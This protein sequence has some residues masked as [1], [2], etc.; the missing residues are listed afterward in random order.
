MLER[1]IEDSARSLGLPNG[2]LEQLS[3]LLTALILDR[4]HG[5]LAGFSSSFQ[6]LGL[7][8]I[9]ASWSSGQPSQPISF[10]EVK[11]VFGVP[12]IAAM[13]GKLGLG[14]VL[15]TRALC[16]LLPDLIKVLTLGDQSPLAIPA[17]LRSSSS[18][19]AEWLNEMDS[20]RWVA[21]RT[22]SPLQD[23]VRSQSKTDLCRG[24]PNKTPCLER[25]G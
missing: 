7:Q 22:C 21:W 3:G 6:R 18:G 19:V 1:S 12:L 23:A 13:G 20:A 16:L 17:S 4:R 8:K 5:G 11:G 9:F 24:A 25:L 14:S 10:D 2:K 15:T